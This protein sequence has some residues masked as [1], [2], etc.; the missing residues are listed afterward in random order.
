LKF[1]V[2]VYDLTAADFEKRVENN[3][4]LQ[5]S[6]VYK[7]EKCALQKRETQFRTPADTK[8]RRINASSTRVVQNVIL[9]SPDSHHCS[10]ALAGEK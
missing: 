2:Q 5:K 4:L 1:G 8:L 6:H 7:F 9:F 10:S 3:Y